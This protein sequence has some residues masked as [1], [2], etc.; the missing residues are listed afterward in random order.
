MVVEERILARH[1]TDKQ[2]L[3]ELALVFEM[4]EEAILGDSD[5]GNQLV[6]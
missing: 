3:G 4:I 5:R 1:V 6:D 2:C